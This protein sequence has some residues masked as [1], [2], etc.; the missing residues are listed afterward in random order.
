MNGSLPIIGLIGGIGSGKSTVAKVLSGFG[1]VVADADSNAKAVLR[2]SEIREQ[3]T[4][5]WGKTILN[6]DG[7]V[8]MG[9]VSDIVFQ[10][11]A[12]RRKLEELIHP[13]VKQMQEAQFRASPQGTRGLVIDAPLLLEAGFEKDCDYLI[14]VET[15]RDIRLRRVLENRGWSKEELDRREQAQLPLDTK[16]DKA[17]YVLINEGKLDEVHSQVKQILDDIDNRRLV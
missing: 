8:D 12:E 14:Y 2:D 16:R 4:L 9:A 10:N 17:D 6:I 3:L 5:W 7:L 13:R 15:S 11:D 1:C